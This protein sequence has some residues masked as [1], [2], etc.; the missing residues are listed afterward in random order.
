M[1]PKP[2][3]T[4]QIYRESCDL[5]FMGVAP[6]DKSFD[7]DHCE[8]GAGDHAY[9][10]IVQSTGAAWEQASATLAAVVA[11]MDQ[12]EAAQVCA[13]WVLVMNDIKVRVHQSPGVRMGL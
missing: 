3:P 11:D 7:I 6:R 10:L 5:Q 12:H 9:P 13:Q 4:D 8:S 1:T 2:L